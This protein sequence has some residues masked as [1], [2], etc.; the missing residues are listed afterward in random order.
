[1]LYAAKT[2]EKAFR[3]GGLFARKEKK[4]SAAEIR[5]ALGLSKKQSEDLIKALF[6]E[7]AIQ[8]EVVYP[9]APK[10]GERRRAVFSSFEPEGRNSVFAAVGL[11]F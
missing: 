11:D 3:L 4:M 2:L 9:I 1:M 7:G 8:S 5:A 10:R 6:A